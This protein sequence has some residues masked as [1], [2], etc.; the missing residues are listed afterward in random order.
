VDAIVWWIDSGATTHVCKDRCWLKTYEP[1]E[2]GY[3]LYM[4]DDHFA[5]VHGK[6]SVVLEF[7]LG[8]SITLFK[9]LY[10][11]KLRKNLIYG[12]I[13]NKC[14]YKQVYESDKYIL[15]KSGVFVG[16]GYYNNGMFMLNLNKVPD[17]SSSVYMSSSTVVNSSLWLARL[18]HVHYKRMLEMSKDD[19]I[20]AIDENPEK[21]T[22]CM[23]T[24]TTRKPFK[25]IIRKSVIL[26]L[27][28]SDLCD[29]HATSSLG[30]KK[31]IMEIML[32]LLK[33]WNYAYGK[34]TDKLPILK[35]GEYEMW[36][37]RIKQYFHIQDYALWE[38]IKNGNSWV[39]IPQ[40]PQENG[41]SVTKMSAPV[42]AEEKTNKKN[43]Q[44][45]EN[46]SA[47]SAET[48]DSIFNRLQKIISR[49]VILD[50]VIVQEDLNSKFLNILP[51]EWN[52]HV[53][54][55][56]NKAE[57]ETMS[58]DDL[59]NNFK[60]AEQS[61]KKSVSASSGAQNLAFITASRTSSTNDVNT[62]IPAY[63]VSTASP[64]VNAASPQVSTASFSDNAV[65]A[66]LVE[67]PNGSNLLQ[68]DLEQIHK[69]D[70]EAMD[71]KWQLSLLSMREKRYY[72]RIGKKIF[73]VRN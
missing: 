55:W 11:P 37:I 26:E 15:S 2:D 73:I 7:S 16:F 62:A 44:Q 66:F 12:P 38:V 30:N 70:L 5:L 34:T 52:T 61:V 32:M 3:V 56:M 46:F 42:T 51:P 47:S 29:F 8:K 17:D 67:N 58:I 23:L 72:Q 18:G 45:Y 48:L 35:L 60:I 4:G 63:E 57:I 24:K 13:L 53:V 68:Q 49:L 41:T 40:T 6:G 59:Y 28:H 20:P 19:L 50:V 1:V 21:Y 33:S 39:S 71:L 64:N 10:V 69:D 9:V 14:R 25:S 65:Y 27:I 43:D 31:Y 22:T 36:V 54:V